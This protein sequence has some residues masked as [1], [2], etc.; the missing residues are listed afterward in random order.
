MRNS[1]KAL[2]AGSILLILLGVSFLIFYKR[3]QHKLEQQK[4]PLILTSAVIDR[5]LPRSNLVNISGQALDDEKLRRGKIIL[6]FM[7]PECQ[8]CDQEN[9]FLSTVV[10]LRKDVSFVFVIPFG[11]KDEALKL[12]Q[13]R[14]ASEAFFDSGSTVARELQLYQVPVKV[15]LEDG[16]IKKTWLDATVDSKLQDEFRT[17]LKNI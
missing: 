14:Y 8:P 15:F 3:A 9:Q 12:A 17:W 6:V 10:S 11:N 5:P 1:T 4:T 13:G 2:S 16:I 7:K